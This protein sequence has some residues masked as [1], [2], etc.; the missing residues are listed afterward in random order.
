MAVLLGEIREKMKAEKSSRIPPPVPRVASGGRD[1]E[2][3]SRDLQ[4]SGSN[5]STDL[6]GENGNRRPHPLD[7]KSTRLGNL[8]S[9]ITLQESDSRTCVC[10][11]EVILVLIGIATAVA[12]FTMTEGP[13]QSGVTAQ[14][15]PPTSLPTELPSAMPTGVPTFSPTFSP[16]FT[17]TVTP[18][19][20]PTRFPTTA[21][22]GTVPSPPT[23]LSP[24]VTCN[25]ADII[26]VVFGIGTSISVVGQGLNCLPSRY[27]EPIVFK[28]V[29]S[30]RLDS[31]NIPT[32]QSEAF[33][34]L[35]A[36]A[37]LT[38]RDNYI[39]TIEAD[40]LK[41][42]TNL[43]SLS[44]TSNQL[45]GFVKNIHT[46]AFQDLVKLESLVIDTF[47][48]TNLDAALF[49]AMSGLTRIRMRSGWGGFT[50]PN[51]AGL[52]VPE[53]SFSA[54]AKLT[55]LDVSGLGI[56]PTLGEED[57]PML[58]NETLTGL[59]LEACG[60]KLVI[61]DVLSKFTALK[62]LELDA[63][64]ITSVPN[65]LP[66]TLEQFFAKENKLSSLGA[67]TTL[68][69]LQYLFLRTNQIT[70]IEPELSQLTKLTSIILQ[71]NEISGEVPPSAF[72]TLGKLTF[73]DLSSNTKLEFVNE[74]FDGVPLLGYFRLDNSGITELPENLL[75]RLSRLTTL[76]L[77]D[78]AITELPRGIFDSSTKLRYLDLS[79]NAG[80]LRFPPGVFSKLTELTSLRA[81]SVI[82]FLDFPCAQVFLNH[83][84]LHDA[85]VL[86]PTIPDC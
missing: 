35:G 3:A 53:N 23:T 7:R 4:R 59:H 34:G 50:L 31:N 15:P 5:I 64:E 80:R 74:S 85:S 68:T 84:G 29:T 16:S 9:H 6:N 49:T 27:F 67:L 36:L 13:S 70:T 54:M 83:T 78:N 56:G 10:V 33:V 63:N 30:I 72:D 28:D 40:G 1:A 75:Q 44:L 47:D 26:P 76:F 52:R 73:L 41:S 62:S 19:K 57:L 58:S 86:L 77:N 32:V 21:P 42:L 22:S 25:I 37:S 65:N 20:R 8:V 48:L 11:G 39:E 51:R 18:T 71:A 79:R 46:S 69:N 60:I 61:P 38:L 14:N 2:A 81:F 82:S 17:P 24:T 43:L 12:T 45:N 66:L 55:S